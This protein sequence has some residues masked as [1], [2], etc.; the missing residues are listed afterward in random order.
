MLSY[1][2]LMLRWLLALR[3]LLYAGACCHDADAAA[4]ML[5]R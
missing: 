5:M 3:F 1:A 2:M 4:Q